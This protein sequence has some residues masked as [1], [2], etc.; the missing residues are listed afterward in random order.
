MNYLETKNMFEN[1]NLFYIITTNMEGN[2]TL[3]NLI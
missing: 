2:Y 3:Y 1:S